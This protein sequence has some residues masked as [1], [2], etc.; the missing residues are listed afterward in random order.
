M[1]S[2]CQLDGRFCGPQSLQDW[3]RRKRICVLPLMSISSC[4]SSS[5]PISVDRTAGFPSKLPYTV[6]WTRSPGFE[7]TGFSPVTSFSP[8][9][10]Y[11]VSTQLYTFILSAPYDLSNRKRCKIKYFSEGTPCRLVNKFQLVQE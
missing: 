7:S 10:H 4:S 11:T 2:L 5:Q 3:W 1:G 9:S 8:V 6:L